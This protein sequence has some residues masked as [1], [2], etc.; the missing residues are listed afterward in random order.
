MAYVAPEQC[1]WPEYC[2]PIDYDCAAVGDCLTIETNRGPAGNAHNITTDYSVMVGGTSIPIVKTSRSFSVS[3]SQTFGV[4]DDVV[5]YNMVDGTYRAECGERSPNTA[6]CTFV[7]DCV[8]ERSILHYV[9]H[10][11]GVC[12]YQYIKDDLKINITSSEMAS[13]KGDWGQILTHQ[14]LIRKGDVICTRNEEWRLI[15][16]GV[17]KV[18]TTRTVDLV[19]FE[20]CYPGDDYSDN[21]YPDFVPEPNVVQVLVFPQPP[22]RGIPWTPEIRAYGFYDYATPEGNESELNAADGGNK[23]MFYPAWCRALFTDPYWRKA[24]DDRY[25][26]SWFHAEPVNNGSYIP[27]EVF[28]SPLPRG[29]FVKHPIVGE[30]YQ[31]LVNEAYGACT[32]TSPDLNNSIDNAL[33]EGLSTHDTTLYYPI[34]VV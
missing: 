20:G 31:F 13:F 7:E 25:A 30:V 4:P 10:R 24:A 12:L 14:V 2:S 29:T 26:I 27:D 19:P 6:T 3:Y 21:L 8:I 11:Y 16:S 33:A 15:V 34:G 17:E 5:Y 18:L 1:S 32:E 22:S 23:D 28:N 9:D